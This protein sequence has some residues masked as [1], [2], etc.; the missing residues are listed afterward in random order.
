LPALRDVSLFEKDPGEEGEDDGDELGEV[1]ETQTDSEEIISTTERGA[2]IG[3]VPDDNREVVL[4]A[5]EEEPLVE[6]Q[7]SEISHA[8]R[9]AV[10]E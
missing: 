6:E 7:G 9:R 5:S 1:V 4:E 8:R 3:E 10:G 2:N